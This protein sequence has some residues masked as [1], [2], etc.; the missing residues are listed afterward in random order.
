MV[1]SHGSVTWNGRSRPIGSQ[2]D[3]VLRLRAEIERLV[4]MCGKNDL[5]N[6]GLK[7]KC[8]GVRS[9]T[10]GGVYNLSTKEQKN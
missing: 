10:G 4:M 8:M 2:L 3:G 7:R 5:V 1:R 9:S 6:L